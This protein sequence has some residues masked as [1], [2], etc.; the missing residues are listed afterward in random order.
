MLNL[1][2]LMKTAEERTAEELKGRVAHADD[3]PRRFHSMVAKYLM[4]VS[5]CIVTPAPWNA[6]VQLG[7]KR[8]RSSH[9]TINI[10]ASASLAIAER[11]ASAGEPAAKKPKK[12]T[13]RDFFGKST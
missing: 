2:T 11:A 10:H 5:G 3:M 8:E 1:L 7:I 9:N 4:S 13:I 12:G 6:C